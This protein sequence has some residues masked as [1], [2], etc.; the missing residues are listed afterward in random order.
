MSELSVLS[1][2]IKVYFNS[3]YLLDNGDFPES[4]RGRCIIRNYLLSILILNLEMKPV[5]CS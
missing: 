4:R 2:G 3:P 1:S 5:D